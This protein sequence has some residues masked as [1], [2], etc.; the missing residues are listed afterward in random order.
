MAD[1]KLHV[2]VRGLEQTAVLLMRER[3]HAEHMRLHLHAI[4][5]GKPSAQARAAW[6]RAGGPCPYQKRLEARVQAERKRLPGGE[7]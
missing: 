2:D 1:P 6:C 7:L 5:D 3:A 4:L